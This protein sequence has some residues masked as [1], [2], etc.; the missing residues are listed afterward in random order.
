M[1]RESWSLKQMC[2]STFTQQETEGYRDSIPR[3]VYNFGRGL[4]LWALC[5]RARRHRE[6]AHQGASNCSSSCERQ[7]IEI[8][9]VYGT[10]RFGT[11]CCVLV[12]VLQPWMLVLWSLCFMAI[13]SEPSVRAPRHISK[14]AQAGRYPRGI[15]LP[16]SKVMKT[17]RTID[18][19][20]DIDRHVTVVS[21]S[22]T[23]AEFK[24]KACRNGF[25]F[26]AR[27]DQRLP[28]PQS[29]TCGIKRRSDDDEPL[30][31]PYEP[32]YCSSSPARSSPSSC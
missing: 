5:E 27:N 29:Q 20:C 15:G 32:Q 21:C 2:F 3:F 6:S 30:P 18:D 1:A 31:V 25:E 14:G 11:P 28:V 16:S 26:F 4:I 23:V 22:Q 7:T 17:L 9:E 12:C 19:C 24:D 8:E 13:S 10:C